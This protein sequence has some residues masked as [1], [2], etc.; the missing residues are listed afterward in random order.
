MNRTEVPCCSQHRSCIRVIYAVLVSKLD[1]SPYIQNRIKFFHCT[2][3]GRAPFWDKWVNIVTKSS[4]ALTGQGGT[5]VDH[6]CNIQ[7]SC[8]TIRSGESDRKMNKDTTV[9][10]N[11]GST[12]FTLKWISLPFPIAKLLIKLLF[13]VLWLQ[14]H[15]FQ[16]Q[17]RQRMKSSK[18][19]R[20]PTLLF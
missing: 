1:Q 15:Y 20:R 11:K 8:V 12:F 5:P 2:Q 18:K 3:Y 10:V 6:S 17:E 19:A 14:H 9:V 16:I 13:S 4:Q 7:H